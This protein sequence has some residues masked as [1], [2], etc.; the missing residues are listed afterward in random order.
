MCLQENPSPDSTLSDKLSHDL[1]QVYQICLPRLPE[2]ILQEGSKID[3]ASYSF[4]ERH[5]TRQDTEYDL[6]L[7]QLTVTST[8]HEGHLDTF[9]VVST[10]HCVHST[11]SSFFPVNNHPLRRYS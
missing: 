2:S 6:G 4:Y 10:S 11:T 5:D 3:D 8:F 1:A 9:D 7:I